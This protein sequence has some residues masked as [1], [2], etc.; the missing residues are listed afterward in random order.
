MKAPFPHVVTGVRWDEAIKR[1][2]IA[3]DRRATIKSALR[4]HGEMGCSTIPK[5][6]AFLAFAG[7][8]AGLFHSAP[9]DYE[10]TGRDQKN[11]ALEKLADK[12]VAIVGTGRSSVCRPVR[13]LGKIC[14][15]L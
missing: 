13:S 4:H 8:R 7:S 10:Y 1:W 6:L 12:R 3:T 14:S 9:W 5:L 2:R 11:P 15:R